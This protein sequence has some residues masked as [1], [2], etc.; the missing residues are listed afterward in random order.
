MS[1]QLTPFAWVLC[2]MICALPVA[3]FVKTKYPALFVRARGRVSAR[4]KCEESPSTPCESAEESFFA[5]F[6]EQWFKLAF[7]FE[8]FTFMFTNLG[9]FAKVNDKLVGYDFVASMVVFCLS[10]ILLC[11]KKYDK[12]VLIMGGALLFS[13]W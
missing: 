8:L 2:A 1:I 5:R 11:R 10:L 3:A 6:I 12:R 9:Y 7:I 4:Q 13:I